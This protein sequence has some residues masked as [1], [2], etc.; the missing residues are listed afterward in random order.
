[1]IFK[2]LSEDQR[3]Y[4]AICDSIDR[5]AE[6]LIDSI[7]NEID[8]KVNDP[9]Q[10]ESAYVV[11]KQILDMADR[12][13]ETFAQYKVFGTIFPA[14]PDKQDYATALKEYYEKKQ[15]LTNLQE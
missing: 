8:F 3:V 7:T 12:D 5:R 15:G 10:I 1:M 6:K 9:V 14:V 2:T 4:Q 13:K 11:I